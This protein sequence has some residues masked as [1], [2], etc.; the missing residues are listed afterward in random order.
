M[1]FQNTIDHIDTEVT[2]LLSQIE[3]LKRH[4]AQLIE[5]DT[6]TGSTLGQLGD[7]V[8]KIGDY[9]P[10]A[11]ASLR[12]AVLNLFDSGDSGNGGGND[13]PTDPTPDAPTPD[14]DL[15]KQESGA[16]PVTLPSAMPTLQ[17][18]EGVANVEPLTGQHCQLTSHWEHDWELEPLDGQAWEIA[19]PLCCLLSDAPKHNEDKGTDKAEYR[20]YIELV[21][22]PENKAIAYQRKHDGEII[23]T[24]IGF[25]TKAIAQSWIHYVEAITSG[26]ELRS[27]KRMLGFK[28]EMK[29]KGMSVRQIERLATEDI[30]KSYSTKPSQTPQALK[31]EAGDIVTQLLTPSHSYRVEAILPNGVLDCTNLVTSARLGLRPATVSLV[32]KASKYP[33]CPFQEGDLV[34]WRGLKLR[35]GAIGIETLHCVLR[36]DPAGTK[37]HTRVPLAECTMSETAPETREERDARIAQENQQMLSG[38][39]ATVFDQNFQNQ[40]TRLSMSAVHGR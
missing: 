36:T 14:A 2:E 12:N 17:A 24:Y 35:V 5:L 26:V 10:S 20:A 34:D 16:N 25:R 39:A 13:Q 18:I 22:H 15:P 32:Q 29:I 27:S 11:I 28:W 33:P 38:M 8:S 30:S 31:I 3:D 21:S 37:P 7:V 40:N 6:L 23:C 9:A 19:T 4:Q 1:I